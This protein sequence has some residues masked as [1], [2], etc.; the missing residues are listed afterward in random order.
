MADALSRLLVHAG[1]FNWDDGNEPKLLHRHQVTRGEVEQVFFQI[2]LLLSVDLK[3]SESEPRYIALGRTMDAR[4][5]QI[6]FTIRGDLIRPLSA[7][8]M[9]RKERAQYDQASS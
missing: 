3:H 2:R 6:V 1:G 7:R 8:P 4:M 5:L 9:K